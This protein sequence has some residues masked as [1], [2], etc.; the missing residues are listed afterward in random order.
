MQNKDKKQAYL[1]DWAVVEFPVF[2]D[3]VFADLNS[4]HPISL[5]GRAEKDHRADPVTGAFADGHRIIT[6]RIV[7][8][9]RGKIYTENTLY[10]LGEINENYLQWCEKNG[11]AWQEFRDLQ[12]VIYEPEPQTKADDTGMIKKKTA[13][14]LLRHIC[15]NCGKEE[16]LTSEEGFHKGWDYPPKMGAFGVISPRTCGD[17][18]IETTL[19]WELTINKTPMEKLSPKHHETL[20]RILDE[21]ESITP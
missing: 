7:Q 3:A 18:G 14:M 21:P 2:P 17:C 8:A 5:I 12:F 20:K 1:D 13:D 19:W 15:E 9:D 16:V 4:P 11:I 6:T 10:T